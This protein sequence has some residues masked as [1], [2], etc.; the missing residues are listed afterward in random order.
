MRMSDYRQPLRDVYSGDLTTATDSLAAVRAVFEVRADAD[1]GALT[2][3]AATLALA[4]TAPLPVNCEREGP[5]EILMTAVLDGITATAAD[6]ILRK[7]KQLSVVVEATV[8][9][10]EMPRPVGVPPRART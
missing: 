5:D 6:L 9:C 10:E 3:V 7:L 2:R 1:P 8:I 4:N